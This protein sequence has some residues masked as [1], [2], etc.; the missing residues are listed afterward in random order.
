MTH[1]A[2][3]KLLPCIWCPK[4]IVKID[5]DGVDM[6]VTCL[7]CN[8]TGPQCDEV[9]DA[10]R[11][12]NTRRA[13][14]AGGLTDEEAE[15]SRLTAEVEAYK[16]EMQEDAKTLKAQRE[17]IEKLK[18]EL[19]DALASQRMTWE[20]AEMA[21]AELAALKSTA[22]ETKAALRALVRHTKNREDCHL[23]CVGKPDDNCRGFYALAA[24]GDKK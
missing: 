3:V 16:T 14:L 12:W 17:A 10:V 9:E 2:E 7:S 20:R 22:K 23:C 13:P 11:A 19:G 6:W 21:E 24:L 8:G 4:S 18:A 15:L 5:G 1:P